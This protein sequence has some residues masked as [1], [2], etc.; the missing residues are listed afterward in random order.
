MIIRANNNIFLLSFYHIAIIIIIVIR[1]RMII[2]IMIIIMIIIVIIVIIIVIKIV[3][4]IVASIT[5]CF[6]SRLFPRWIRCAMD[7]PGLTHH[8]QRYY[9]C[10]IYYS[11]L[12]C[13][14]HSKSW[15]GKAFSV[16]KSTH[17]PN[18]HCNAQWALPTHI[19][20]SLNFCHI[21]T[22]PQCS[23]LP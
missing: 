21:F 12:F 7:P 2:V 8:S 11:L 9:T 4:I 5:F 18:L 3:I 6:L 15:L 13:K 1:L 20:I 10:I 17:K 14:L 16:E 19:S 22:E 23:A